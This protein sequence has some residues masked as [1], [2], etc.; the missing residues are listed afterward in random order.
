MELHLNNILL[1]VAVTFTVPLTAYLMRRIGYEMLVS[2]FVLVVLL[3]NIFV[4]EPV[5]LV[6]NVVVTAGL[7]LYGLTYILTDVAHEV[8]GEEKARKMVYIGTLVA[9]LYTLTVL[10]LSMLEPLPTWRLREAFNEIFYVQSPRVMLA[11][12]LVFFISNLLDVKLFEKIRQAT[13]G[14]HLWLRNIVAEYVADVVDTTLFFTLAFAGV[15]SWSLIWTVIYS[16]LIG[17]WMFHGVDT[18]Q[19][20]VAKYILTRKKK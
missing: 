20:Y 11:S 17:K 3:C 13:R 6:D 7:Y 4:L 19:L 18:F 8:Y 12:V 10:I 9:L 5:P 15:W 16:T 14:R 1:M 2:F